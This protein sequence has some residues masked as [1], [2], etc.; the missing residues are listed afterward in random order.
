MTQMFFDNSKFFKFVEDCRAMDINVPIIPGLKP[1]TTMRHLTFL[2]KV[3]AIDL[4]E[5]LADQ[6]ANCS[7]NEEVRKVGTAWCIQQSQEL[8]EFGVPC[9]HYYTMGRSAVVKAICK[10][11]F[12]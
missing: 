9:L 1:I 3:F 11:V 2:P 8:M 7:T 6:L 5:A 4:P 10:E 12:G